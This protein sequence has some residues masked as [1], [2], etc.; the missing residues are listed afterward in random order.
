MGT[1]SLNSPGYDIPPEM[2]SQV[3]ITTLDK[4]LQL[5]PEKFAL[6]N[7]VWSGMLCNR[8][9]RYGRQSF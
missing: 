3:A 4:N 9:D 1:E 2:Q 5:E 6:A 8:N 7:D